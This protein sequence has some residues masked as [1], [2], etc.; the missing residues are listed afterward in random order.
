MLNTLFLRFCLYILYV[1]HDHVELGCSPLSV[2]CR[3]IN[4]HYIMNSKVASVWER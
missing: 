3:Y 4:D 2:R 1:G